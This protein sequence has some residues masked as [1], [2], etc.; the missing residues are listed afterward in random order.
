MRV[1]ASQLSGYRGRVVT[2][3][4]RAVREVDHRGN[5]Q[6]QIGVEADGQFC[7]VELPPGDSFEN[8]AEFIQVSGKVSESEDGYICITVHSA[9]TAGVNFDLGAYNQ[10]LNLAHGKYSHLFF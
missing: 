2:L 1:Q 7:G 4:G 3:I 6:I 8:Y 9:T 10:T 5:L